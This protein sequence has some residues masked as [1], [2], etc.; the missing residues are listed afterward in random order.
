M[1][2]NHGARTSRRA[3]LAERWKTSARGVGVVSVLAV[4]GVL[5]AVVLALGVDKP[6]E[7]AS[8]FPPEADAYVHE[9]NSN[10]NYGGS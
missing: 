2:R 9:L 5:A 6:A 7:A 3:R 4:V 8:A 1:R 10:T